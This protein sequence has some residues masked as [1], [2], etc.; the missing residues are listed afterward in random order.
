MAAAGGCGGAA[1]RGK[2]TEETVSIENRCFSVFYWVR[3]MFGQSIHLSSVPANSMLIFS[4]EMVVHSDS[5]VVS[6]RVM[7][8]RNNLLIYVTE[9][10]IDA[11]NETAPGLTKLAVYKLLFLMYQ[12]LKEQG[13]DMKL[14]YSWYLYG[15]MTEWNGY[16]RA[17]GNSLEEYFIGNDAVNLLNFRSVLEIGEEVAGLVQRIFSDFI[18]KY[19]AGAAW[20]V[21]LMIRDAY[22]DAP[23]EFQRVYTLELKKL[24]LQRT[25][26]PE[27]VAVLDRLFAVFPEEELENIYT[28]YL[29]WDDTFRL[30]LRAGVAN[31]MRK[32]LI[33]QFWNVF[34]ARVRCS[35]NENVTDADREMF[36]RKLATAR[37]QFVSWL[38]EVREEIFFQLP[39][40]SL[41]PD[42]AGL[43]A[44]LNAVA[45]D[46]VV[47]R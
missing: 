41:S 20:D 28:V 5:T 37:E 44:E 23:F 11:G 39:E 2:V 31:E 15:P 7:S 40:S 27:I 38:R 21:N 36:V 9:Y 43:L 12:R 35:E 19:A 16:C 29:R 4:S 46:A 14:P 18:R 32:E 34:A 3:G 45:F 26:V 24:K 33:K 22:A 17:T 10:I 42:D 13:V 30:A 25:S 47:R 1:G 6:L 8:E